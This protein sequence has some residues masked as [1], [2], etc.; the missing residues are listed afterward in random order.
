MTVLAAATK[1]GQ[2]TTGEKVDAMA[3]SV[4]DA[5]ITAQVKTTQKARCT[6]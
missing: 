5:S 3:K 2:K 6:K 4:D 1:P